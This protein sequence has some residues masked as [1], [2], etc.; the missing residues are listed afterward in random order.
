MTDGRLVARFGLLPVR[1]VDVPLDAIQDVD[2]EQTFL[3][4]LL[5]Y[6]RVYVTARDEGVDTLGPVP[7]P[8]ELRA[9]LLRGRAGGRRR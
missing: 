7:A 5:G 4:R 6:G 1:R 3:G 2:V 9:A 8:A